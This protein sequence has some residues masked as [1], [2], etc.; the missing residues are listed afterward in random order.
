M[1]A[2]DLLTTSEI[3]KRVKV[4]PTTIRSWTRRGLIPAVR[5]SRK[6]IR[7]NL[8]AVLAAVAANAPK[9]VSRG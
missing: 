3:A 7:F 4:S 6:V 5:L 8:D 9:G 2:T 1:N